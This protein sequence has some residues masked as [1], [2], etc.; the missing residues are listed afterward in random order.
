[1]ILPFLSE[2]LSVLTP[3]LPLLVSLYSS[4]AVFLPYPFSVTTNNNL[5]GS[6]ISAPTQISFDKLIPL[7]PEAVLPIILTSFAANLTI[8]PLDEHINT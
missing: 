2:I 1:M 3:L 8:L 4:I 6:D 7:T 5:P